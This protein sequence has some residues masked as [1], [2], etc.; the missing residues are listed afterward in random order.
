MGDA[1]IDPSTLGHIAP[2]HQLEWHGQRL[3]RGVLVIHCDVRREY[4][5]KFGSQSAS[6]NPWVC[7]VRGANG[8][9]LNEAS[10]AR[11]A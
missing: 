9:R 5:V 4:A 1:D 11:R 3:R 6:P 8:A 7:T 10:N 2:W